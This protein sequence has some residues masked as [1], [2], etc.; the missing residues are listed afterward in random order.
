MT[1]VVPS[2]EKWELSDQLGLGTKVLLKFT[3]YYLSFTTFKSHWFET[4]G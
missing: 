1:L 4:P 2:V 3:K